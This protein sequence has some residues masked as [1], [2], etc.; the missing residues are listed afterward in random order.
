MSCGVR[1]RHSLDPAVL[2][3][4]RTPAATAPIH[5][6][7]W[8]PPYAMGAALKRQNTNKKKKKQQNVSLNFKVVRIFLVDN[9]VMT[10]QKS[11]SV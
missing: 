2:C 11:C 8:N 3:L 9:L 6:P 1:R 7:A 5:P 10:M 4:A